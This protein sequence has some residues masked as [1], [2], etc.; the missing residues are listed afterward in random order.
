MCSLWIL[1]N[2]LFFYIIISFMKKKLTSV[3]QK[4]YTLKVALMIV[5]LLVFD[6]AVLGLAI[7]RRSDSNKGPEAVIETTPA[8]TPVSTTPAA[9]APEPTPEPITVYTSM[10]KIPNDRAEYKA[11]D[12]DEGFTSEWVPS[13]D[14]SNAYVDTANTFETIVANV[15][16]TG[17]SI[18]SATVSRWGIPFESGK[19]YHLFLNASSSIP[20]KIQL[21]AYNGDTGAGFGSTALS[22]TQDMQ[23]FEWNFTVPS[24]AGGYNGVL[25]FDLGNN[26]ITDSH[27]VTIHALRIIGNDDNEAVRVNQLGYLTTE[28]KRCTFIYSCG[29]LFDVVNADTNAIAYSGAIV[30][31]T[32]DAY[33]GETNYYGD[34]TNLQVPGTY[35]IRTQSGLISQ[36]F[37]INGDP[38]SVLQSSAIRMLSY[39]RCGSEL[40]EWAGEAAHPGCHTADANF[41]LTDMWVNVTGGWHDAGDFG[42]YVS[43]GTKAVNDLMLAYLT[44]PDEFTDEIGG[45]DSGNGIADILDE[46]RYEMEF[47][48]KMQMDDGS[49]FCKATSSGFPPDNTAPEADQLPVLLFAPDTVSTAD[50]EGSFAIAAMAFREIDPDFAN[51]CLEAARKADK[52]LAGHRD[53]TLTM[54]PPD[55]SAGQYLDDSD[56]DAR[57]TAKMALY[58]ATGETGF[59]EDARDIYNDDRDAVINSVSWKN[60][61]IFGVYLFLTSPNGE[62]D[63]PEF[64]QTMMDELRDTADHLCNIANGSGYNVANTLY[65]WGSNSFVAN[66][67]IVLAMAYDITGDQKY[68][69]MA[70]EQLNYI[71]GKNCLDY[72]FVSGFGTRSPKN[73][74]N[75]LTIAKQTMI[76]GALSGGPDASRE[77]D[78]MEAMPWETPVAKMYA[79]DHRSF[80]TNEVAVYYNSALIYLITAIE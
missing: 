5:A 52:Y 40:G 57:F 73:Q 26:G 45:P 15:G 16:A 31:R 51:R 53:Y 67:G 68:E 37:V 34:F 1:T 44:A 46:A 54:N 30:H 32:Q 80:S 39:Q 7:H 8:P 70:I 65:E 43:T 3:L 10:L 9:S 77:D 22:L 28:Q 42:R 58:A 60:N 19:T 61:G 72:C 49:V 23:Y 64:Y 27:T 76:E 20:R 41:Y 62:T 63:D 11:D 59:L 24:G 14:E 25:S 74:H 2:R 18:T 13:F 17:S 6:A 29:D 56:R 12:P 35:F 36:P 48:L 47:L 66:C 50:A 33:T 21:R 71:L 55:I 69:Q 78:I 4:T 79:D 38:Y 75:R